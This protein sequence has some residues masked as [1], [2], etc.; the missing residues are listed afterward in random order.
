MKI[1]GMKMANYWIV[2]FFFNL[3][4]Y[5]ITVVLFMLFGNKV[6]GLLVFAET[7]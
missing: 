4:F 5:M 7:N 2:N 3:A 1:N 6:F